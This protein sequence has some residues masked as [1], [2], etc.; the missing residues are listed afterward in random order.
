MVS[1]Y[2]IRPLQYK[3]YQEQMRNQP[4]MLYP[5]Q[6][7]QPVKAKS[8]FQRV[9]DSKRSNNKKMQKE[10]QKKRLHFPASEKSPGKGG[11]INLL[12]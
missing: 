4:A 9:L 5:I 11:K 3:E 6:S 12:V 7:A 8:S 2:P 1:I 10:N